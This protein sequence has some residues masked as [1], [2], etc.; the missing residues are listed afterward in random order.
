MAKCNECSNAIF[1]PVWG[2]YKCRPNE[3][4]IGRPDQDRR[5]TDFKKG[6]PATSKKY[7]EEE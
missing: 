1:D 6:E 4:P 3:C 5:C 2:V 7:E